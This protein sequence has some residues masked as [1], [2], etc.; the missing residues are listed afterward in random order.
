MPRSP[1]GSRRRIA[2]RPRMPRMSARQVP[3]IRRPPSEE[4]NI[5]PAPAARG[6][7]RHGDR[8]RRAASPQWRLA[9]RVSGPPLRS[10][11][12]GSF[13]A[14]SIADARRASS[15][16]PELERHQAL[17]RR[18]SQAGRLPQPGRP[19][20]CLCPASDP[21]RETAAQAAAAARRSLG[22]ASAE[23]GPPRRRRRARAATTARPATALQ[24]GAKHE[25]EMNRTVSGRS[26]T[27][28]RAFRGAHRPSRPLASSSRAQ[29]DLTPPI[30]AQERHAAPEPTA[31]GQRS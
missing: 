21:G 25:T 19:K 6:R 20:P 24:Q 7:C 28:Q 30:P 8:R 9:R 13:A 4:S 15:A 18:P 29:S 23:K 31:S 26:P 11:A 5:G 1:S 12:T 14:V 3:T 10:A 16:A 17:H 22:P 2:T 27:P